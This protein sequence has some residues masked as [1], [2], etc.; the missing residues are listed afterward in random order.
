M[1]SAL[2]SVVAATANLKLTVGRSS[3]SVM[4]PTADD[5]S[6]LSDGASVPDGVPS[7]TVK[8]WVLS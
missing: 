3:S 4:A 1:S 6:G 8:Y 5:L 2:P 7:V